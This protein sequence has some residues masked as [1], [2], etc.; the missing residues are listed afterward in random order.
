M[1][2]K[3][4]SVTNPLRDERITPTYVGKSPLLCFVPSVGPDHPHVC[5]EK[6]QI[7]FWQ[8]LLLGSP[9]RMWGKEMPR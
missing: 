7:L 9:P 4:M 2:G 6:P 3:G 8:F 5:G 1:W